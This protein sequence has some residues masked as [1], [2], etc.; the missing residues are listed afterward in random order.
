MTVIL[1]PTTRVITA[2]DL[3]TRSMRLI[4]AVAAGEVVDATDSVDALSTLNEMIDNWNTERISVYGMSN[5]SY[6]LSAGVASYSY[7]LGGDFDAERPV[8]IRDPFSIY[9]GVSREIRLIPQEIYDRVFM[10]EQPGPWP[11]RVL[12]VNSYPL[13]QMT[14]W[15]VPTVD[16]PIQIPVS[17]LLS[18]IT[19]LSQEILLPPGYLRAL[20]YSLAVELWPEYPNA[21][22]D[23][24]TIK[25][26]AIGSR[27]DVQR[28]NQTDPIATFDDVPF[29]DFPYN[30]LG[31]V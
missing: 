27:A 26:I 25:A 9:N 6:T 8:H 3:I 22:T 15:P 29:A 5:E 14:F 19:A 12:F 24:N 16:L 10:K 18:N 28:A 1:Q 13:A 17:R 30:Y 20:R 23:I 31:D 11:I 7:G 21:S 4:N 2:L